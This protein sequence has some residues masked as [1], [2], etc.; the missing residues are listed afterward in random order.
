MRSAQIICRILRALF[1]FI[2]INQNKPDAMRIVRD[3][4]DLDA[5][6]G[7]LQSD[8]GAACGLSCSQEAHTF[9]SVIPAL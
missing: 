1:G 3:I 5:P 8:V 6:R 4:P 2:G 7:R 9:I